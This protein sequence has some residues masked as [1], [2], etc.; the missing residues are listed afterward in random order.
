MSSSSPEFVCHNC[1]GE[2]SIKAEIK[3]EGSLA[4]CTFC[5]RSTEC[6]PIDELALR[7]D[8][9]FQENYQVAQYS[10]RFDVGE[11]ADN[12]VFEMLETDIEVAQAILR[13]LDQTDWRDQANGAVPF[14]ADDEKYIQIEMPSIEHSSMWEEFCHSIKHVARFFD[15]QA[16]DYLGAIFA[17][18]D[19][20]TTFAGETAIREIDLD[21]ADRFVY[22]ARMA[23]RL[24][25]LLRIYLNPHIELGP[26]PE[27][28]AT[29]GRMNPTGIP[30]FYG[31]LARDTCVAELRPPI[32]ALAVTGQF[33]LV[34]SIKVIDL[35]VLDRKLAEIS[36]FHSDYRR[37]ADQKRF[38]LDFHREIRK[39]ILPHQQELDYLPTQAVAEYLALKSGLDLD[40]IVFSSA[41]SSAVGLNLTLFNH[42][43]RIEGPAGSDEEVENGREY[44]GFM[45]GD[46]ALIVEEIDPESF[47]EKEPGWSPLRLDTEESAT[48]VTTTS[49]SDEDDKREPTLRFVPGSVEVHRVYAAEYS[50]S[51]VTVIDEPLN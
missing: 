35:T 15:D 27:D 4:Q 32:G 11:Y 40:G 45:M 28:R 50:I 18:I 1:I 6:F 24:P 29:A 43:S 13:V 33:E 23:D 48:L 44:R 42:A 26:P 7:V 36:M 12:I 41:V 31:S 38:L 9:V 19:Q 2:E 30:V 5:A 20:H 21:I 16:V 22:R 10:A 49:N 39:P 51:A 34:R 8:E 37:D 25:D 47:P 46:D 14:Y 17:N 3:S